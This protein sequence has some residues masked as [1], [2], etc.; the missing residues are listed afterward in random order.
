MAS[1]EL[2]ACSYL[3]AQFVGG[4]VVGAIC[5]VVQVVV[6]VPM[7]VDPKQM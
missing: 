5:M 4:T 3:P 2:D 6:Q 1:T 7:V